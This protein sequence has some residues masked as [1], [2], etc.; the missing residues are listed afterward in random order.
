MI[1]EETETIGNS[2]QLMETKAHR[3]VAVSW[4]HHS[5]LADSIYVADVITC[6]QAESS[7][8]AGMSGSVVMLQAGSTAKYPTQI[9]KHILPEIEGNQKALE[10]HRT[11]SN[12]CWTTQHS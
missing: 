11:W 1:Q 2:Q 7:Q 8:Q 10:R 4:K 5:K 12:Y 9:S 6:L 3:I